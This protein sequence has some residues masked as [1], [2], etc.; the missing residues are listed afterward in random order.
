MN[1]IKAREILRTIADGRDPATGAPFPP[2]SPYQQAETVRALYTALAALEPAIRRARRQQ[3]AGLSQ[4]GQPTDSSPKPPAD[5]NRPKA[6]APWT[7]EEDQQLRDAFIAQPEISIP[8][9]AAA[10]GRSEGA[11]KARLIKLGLIEDPGQ[12]TTHTPHSPSAPAP[13]PEPPPP[14]TSAPHTPGTIPDDCPF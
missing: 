11:I 6:G 4:T 8:P 3:P 7:A 13:S 2:D 9:L 10:H 12:V 5:P 14:A 1:L